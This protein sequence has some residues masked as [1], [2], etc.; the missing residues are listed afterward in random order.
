MNSLS[1]LNIFSKDI[2]LLSK[3][4][5]DIFGLKEIE[6]SRSNYFIGFD[7]GVSKLG[8]SSFDAYDLL[9]IPKPVNEVKETHHV[10]TFEAKNI[11]EVDELTEKSVANGA[12]LLKSPF[13]T[14]YGWYQ[15]VLED[16]DGNVYRISTM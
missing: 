10:I 9:D 16:I 14:Y 3:F 15:S 1:Y 5:C 4:Y 6:E 12:V 11:Q 2:E 7:T 13:N 8:F